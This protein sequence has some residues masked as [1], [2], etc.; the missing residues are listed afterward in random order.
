MKYATSTLFAA[1][2]LVVL[3]PSP[4]HAKS[5]KTELIQR[6]EETYK[7]TNVSLWDGELKRGGTIMVLTQA[8]STGSLD[9]RATPIKAVRDGKFTTENSLTRS[10]TRTFKKGERVFIQKV[11]IL[12]DVDY[13][14]DTDVIRVWIVSAE[15]SQRQE[16][17]TTHE[18][19]YYGGFDYQFPHNY[20]AT[21]DFAEVKKSINST[22]VS[23][24]EFQATD[25][26]ATVRLGM[27]PQQVEEALGKPGKLIDL[28]AKKIYVYPEF[29]VTFVEGKVADVQ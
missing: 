17:G 1:A 28:G 4:V 22:L 19:R 24:S 23:Q 10:N 5:W 25:S 7:T 29:K 3:C 6:I 14:K 21:A 13:A 27:T 11:K 12:E 9:E 2:L 18:Y 8:G 16:G 26:P 15:G 20:L